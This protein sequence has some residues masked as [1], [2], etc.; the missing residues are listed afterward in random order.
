MESW[1]LDKVTNEDGTKKLVISVK[2][3]KVKKQAGEK[4]GGNAEELG[5]L[6]GKGWAL[7]EEIKKQRNERKHDPVGACIPL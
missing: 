7:Q 4:G 1:N 3:W 6:C 2:L 5:W